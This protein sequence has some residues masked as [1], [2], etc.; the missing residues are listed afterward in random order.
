VR[1]AAIYQAEEKRMTTFAFSPAC[2]AVKTRG[3]NIM[4]TTYFIV[5][6]IAVLILT[7]CAPK[8]PFEVREQVTWR[9]EF[10]ELQANPENYKDEFVILGGRII[11]TENFSDY[12]EITVVQ[13]PLDRSNRPLADNESDGRFLVRSDSFID[14]E[15]Y[16]P[17]RLLT[18][19]GEITGA[20]IRSVGNYPYE[21]PIVRGELYVWEPRGRQSP[22]FQFG[23]G[24]GKTF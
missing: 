13:F 6:A 22:R 23:L 21:H 1:G 15:I 14:P 18:V 24:I 8:I 16:A 19:A 12:S 2:L 3:G 5:T 7:G 20:E 4:R 9:G 17:G 10:R 11:K